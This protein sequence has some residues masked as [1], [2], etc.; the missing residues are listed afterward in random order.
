MNIRRLAHAMT[1][2]CLLFMLAACSSDKEYENHQTLEDESWSIT[3]PVTFSFDIQDTTVPY[4][5]GLDFRYTDSYPWQDIFLFMETTVPDGSLSQDTLHCNL[6]EADGK[7][8]GKGHRI[9][10]LE[11]GY[12]LVRF[13]QPGHYTLR[14]THGMRTETVKG[15]VSFGM[16]LKKTETANP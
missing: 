7:P 12:S 4:L 3:D 15:I 11:V 2:C 1:Y 8:L 16:S 13:P 5:F 10:E 9:K 6:F 14:F